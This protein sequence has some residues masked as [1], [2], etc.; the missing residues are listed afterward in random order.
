MNIHFTIGTLSWLHLGDPVVELVI[1]F[2]EMGTILLGKFFFRVQTLGLVDMDVVV[3]VPLANLLNQVQGFLEVMKSVE[4]D[5]IDHLRAR[6]LEL[7]E[8]IKGDK[9][10]ETKRG[11]LEEMRK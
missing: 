11:G 10:C 5:E 4:E 9:P 2:P 7:R 8:H 6:D 1:P 3:G